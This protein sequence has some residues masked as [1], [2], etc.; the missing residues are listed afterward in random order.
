MIRNPYVQF[1]SLL[2]QQRRWIGKVIGKKDSAL[3][4]VQKL[5]TNS[6]EN[7]VLVSGGNSEIVPNTY[8]L[9]QDTTVVSVLS[10]TQPILSLALV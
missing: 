6:A 9:V 4:Y 10:E 8:V 5:N 2:P 3:V 7:V 1:L